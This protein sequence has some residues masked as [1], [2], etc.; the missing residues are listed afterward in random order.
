VEDFKL[1]SEDEKLKVL[2]A[3]IEDGLPI[4][5][6]MTYYEIPMRN[7]LVSELKTA[8]A[9]CPTH[10]V[11]IVYQQAIDGLP[12]KISPEK[13]LAIESPDLDALLAGKL[14][15]TT[16]TVE[17]IGRDARLVVRKFVSDKLFEMEKKKKPVPRKPVEPAGDLPEE[18]PGLKGK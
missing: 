6:G 12:E 17:K 3:R 5:T 9:S 13:K 14:V 15:E 4:P 11:A 7:V 10:P 1:L 16:A 2:K 8:I 18:T